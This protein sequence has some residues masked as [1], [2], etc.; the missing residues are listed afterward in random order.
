[1]NDMSDSRLV[2]VDPRNLWLKGP[3]STQNKQETEPDG[4][5][6]IAGLGGANPSAPV[7]PKAMAALLGCNVRVVYAMAAEGRIPYL[8]VGARK[9]FE[10]EAVFEALR[11]PVRS[12]SVPPHMAKAG[13]HLKVQ[14]MRR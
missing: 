13:A 9:M 1:M 14:A 2:P 12:M 8:L 7:T 10:P 3:P 4:D 11:Q 5:K 6:A